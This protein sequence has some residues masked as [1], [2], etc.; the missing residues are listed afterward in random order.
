MAADKCELLPELSAPPTCGSSELL[1][2]SYPM[3][4]RWPL[5][6]IRLVMEQQPGTCDFYRTPHVCCDLVR[7]PE[8][9]V[10]REAAPAKF[11]PYLAHLEEPAAKKAKYD[12][13]DDE[14][15]Y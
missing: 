11:N 10:E 9:L 6:T 13:D 5:P 7:H 15:D 1:A 12:E 8:R 2:R 4:P 14:Y 3:P